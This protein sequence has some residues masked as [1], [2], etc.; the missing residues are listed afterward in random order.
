MESYKL[1][2]LVKSDK[3]YITWNKSVRDLINIIC[4]H[5]ANLLKA[6]RPTTSFSFTVN[7]PRYNSPRALLVVGVLLV[8]I[9]ARSLREVKSHM[10]EVK[11]IGENERNDQ[12][13]KMA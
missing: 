8:N 9:A 13:A 11:E 6:F 2:D 10:V 1:W 3:R 7:S 4:L 5:I 12:A